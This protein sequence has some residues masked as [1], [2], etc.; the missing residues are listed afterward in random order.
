[1]NC[2][3][4]FTPCVSG[5]EVC[6][7]CGAHLNPVSG[8]ADGAAALPPPGRLIYRNEETL[9]ILGVVISGF[10]WLGLF[11][12]TVGMLTIILGILFVF[13]LFAHSAFISMLQGSATRITATQ[14]PD[15]HQRVLVCSRQLGVAIPPDA[16]LLHHG[17]MFNA[18][19]TRFLGRNFIVLFSDIVDAL[20]AEP[21]ALNFYIG[22]EL[23]HIRRNHLLWGPFLA[24]ANILP[25]LGSGYSRA[26][27]YTCDMHGMACCATTE[28][29]ARAVAAL[30]AGG[31]R[32]HTLGLA[33]YAAQSN[34][35]GGFWMSYHELTSGYPWL[36]K[37]MARVLAPGT[38]P[39]FPKRHFFAWVLAFF[40]PSGGAITILLVVYMLGI[41]AAV[42]L[43]AY[44]DYTQRAKVSVAITQ[45]Y[46]AAQSV[47]D[48]YARNKKFPESLREAGVAQPAQG[49][50][51]REISLDQDGTLTVTLADEPFA[52]KEFLML[53]TEGA[54]GA[55]T[56]RCR[57]DTVP[58]RYMPA[59]CRN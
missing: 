52:G 13:Y 29:A 4:C 28:A 48:Y 5:D 36:S 23:G 6:S 57:N 47:G 49:S 16:Y 54:S 41:L 45:G 32:W 33:E 59:S 7:A 2:S 10:V 56:W 12:M 14:F 58:P 42:A 27:E 43:P 37:R 35:S 1:M 24:P 9:F 17:G 53:P 25:L 51:A 3:R 39:K 20:E 34:A 46:A 18:L 50:V 44:Q 19:A 11:L 15:L 30:A 22:H 21:E 8:I 38:D 55:I 40:T 26:R 31:K